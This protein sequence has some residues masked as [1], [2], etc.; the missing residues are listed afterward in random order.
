MVALNWQTYDLGLQINEAMFASDDGH[1]GYVLKPQGLRGP[2]A[3]FD[4]PADASAAV[5]KKDMKATKFSVEIISAQ[6]LPKPK[7]HRADKGINP[8]IVVEVF[9]AND[10][11]K[12]ESTAQG[13]IEIDS[14]DSRGATG[15]GAPQR[16]RTRVV[17]DD[18]F[19]PLFKE[20]M[21]FTITTKFEELV[22]VRFSVYNADDGD[23]NGRTALIATYTAKLIFL[24]QGETP[25][26]LPRVSP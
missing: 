13:G 19:H 21:V 26:Y 25:T 3:T 14:S 7:D 22:F 11:A 24:Q 16:R 12:E 6:Q 9:S 18:G 23:S 8:F 20:K 17:K 2:R 4:P 1:G 10:Q 5:L 15:L